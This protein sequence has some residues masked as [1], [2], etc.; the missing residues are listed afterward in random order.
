MCH[1]AG[2]IDS[3]THN[4]VWFGKV[5]YGGVH[6]GAIWFVKTRTA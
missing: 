6:P 5:W 2:C 4:H 3:F 1:M